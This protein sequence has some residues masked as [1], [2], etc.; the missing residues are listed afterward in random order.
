MINCH[1][2]QHS[3]NLYLS[4]S[5]CGQK[6]TRIDRLL[7]LW[8]DKRD[9]L[10]SWWRNS[11]VMTLMNAII[12]VW[13]SVS[14]RKSMWCWCIRI[15]LVLVTSEWLGQ[16][17]SLTRMGRDHPGFRY[18]IG[19]SW[20]LLGSQEEARRVIL[21]IDGSI[22]HLN[23]QYWSSTSTASRSP[24][25]GFPKD[26]LPLWLCVSPQCQLSPWWWTRGRIKCH[27]IMWLEFIIP[28]N[29]FSFWWFKDKEKIN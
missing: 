25:A 15:I 14:M 28:L 7:F 8:P 11:T 5:K 20:I 19:S 2:L 23:C 18:G 29:L 21:V 1:L 4:S 24:A 16:I 10:P 27:L 12:R 6:L 9:R 3:A 17:Y 22:W 26:I 13:L